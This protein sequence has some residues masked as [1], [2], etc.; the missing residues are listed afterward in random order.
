MNNVFLYLLETHPSIYL[1]HQAVIQEVTLLCLGSGCLI[2]LD[3]GCLI[4]LGMGCLHLSGY[5]LPDSGMIV[6]GFI[7]LPMDF[8]ILFSYNLNDS[9]YINIPCFC[10]QFIGWWASRWLPYII[11]KQ[12]SLHM[13]IE[14]FG[15]WPRIVQLDYVVDLLAAFK[16][17]IIKS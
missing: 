8:I 7:H 16:N 9:L 6:S 13:N 17:H 12:V 5:G 1:Y 4:F 14:S 11:D 15:I 3:L 10:W 2:F